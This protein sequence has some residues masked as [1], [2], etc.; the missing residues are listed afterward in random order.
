MKARWLALPVA[1]LGV[2]TLLSAEP[3]L[4]EQ[5]RTATKLSSEALAER[6]G[7]LDCHSVDRKKVG[8][9]YRDVAARYKNDPAARET[10]RN[11]IRNGGKGN[12]LELTG[13][14]PMPPHS[15]LLSRAE[16][17]QLVDWILQR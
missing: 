14:K 1:V 6:T 11:K 4:A 16:I 17:A 12:W 3:P 7:C 2:L 9:A 15:A 5:P 10:L 13:G 8:P